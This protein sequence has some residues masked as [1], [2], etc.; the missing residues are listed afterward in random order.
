[1]MEADR[2]QLARIVAGWELQNPANHCYVNSSVQ[3]MV[4]ATLHRQ[5]FSFEDWGV[6][7]AGLLTMVQRDSTSF[8]LLELAAFRDHMTAWSGAQQHDAVEFT[9]FLMSKMDNAIVHSLWERRFARET[10]AVKRHGSAAGNLM[11]HLKVMPDP[12]QFLHQLIENWHTES[13]V[14]TAYSHLP[15]LVCFHLDRLRPVAG[16]STG[17]KLMSRVHLDAV[18]RIPRF[19]GDDM[20]IEYH[21][22]VPIAA[23]AHLGRPG[24]GHYR[25]ALKCFDAI[26]TTEWLLCDDDA[27]AESA[28]CLPG[29]FETQVTLVWALRRKDLCCVKVDFETAKPPDLSSMLA[30]FA[31]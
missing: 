5:H 14:L 7:Q 23:L 15:S 27:R 4:W 31:D 11:I 1:M 20:M 26:S 19:P 10:G 25:A 30:L 2:N 16:I 22:Y 9:L 24:A 28:S 6:L 3:A 8:L 13:G 18:I 21:E 17:Q 29:W 12:V